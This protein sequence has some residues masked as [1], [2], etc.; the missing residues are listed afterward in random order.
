MAEEDYQQLIGDIKANGYD[1]RQPIYLFENEIID[2]WN[3]YN[4][5]QDLN[6]S[7][8]F[9]DFAGT[10]QE[11]F[12]FVLRS[13]K[14]RNLTSSQWATIAEEAKD[15]FEIIKARVEEN[16]RKKQAEKKINNSNAIKNNSVKQLTELNH[17]PIAK[18]EDNT[19]RADHKLAEIFETNRTYVSAAR[20]IKAADPEIF[21]QVKQGA[22]TI[23]Q[24]QK[25]IKVEAKAKKK[26]AIEKKVSS[27][28]TD[29]ENKTPKIGKECKTGQWWEL[30]DH[31]LFCGDT[32]EK[33]FIDQIK[34]A[35]F[36]FADPP[37]NA[38]VADWDHAFKW[39]HDY[40]SE[41]SP[42]VIVTPG[43][44]A[45]DSFFKNT[46]M[47]Y[48]WA[49]SCWISNG[50]TRGALGF[51]N[52]IFAALF[53]NEKSVYKNAQDHMKISIKTSE[54][55]ETKHKGRKPAEFIANLIELFS[56]EGDIVVDP[57]LGSGTTL[58]VC[59]KFKRKCIGGEIDPISC[60]KII[61]K[62]EIMTGEKA[63]LHH[64]V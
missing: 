16:K 48:K 26:E 46:K 20:K 12:E 59:E 53:S 22:I 3:R 4:A 44:E 42:Y 9:A 5:C 47:P 56:L 55:S 60:G 28:E 51:G 41:I 50:M 39:R 21:E 38:G 7:P 62:W 2:G 25:K 8:T 43:I 30:G 15:V 1:N 61:L 11:A 6:V 13:N 31:L 64:T 32:S 36:V 40:L 63:C 23:P 10:E 54:T 34:K 18:E 24:A 19:T 29:T 52:W 35:A 33:I 49:I 14:R 45:L 27:I 17:A 58:F 37:Y 57:F